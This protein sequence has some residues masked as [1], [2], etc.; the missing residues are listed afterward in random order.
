VNGTG[1]DNEK[2]PPIDYNSYDFDNV[3][4]SYPLAPRIRVLKGVSLKVS[5][6]SEG[7]GPPA[8]MLICLD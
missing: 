8:Q 3:Q 2:Q 6:L 5:T 4:F 1:D 7:P